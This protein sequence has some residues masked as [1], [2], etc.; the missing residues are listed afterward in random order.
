VQDI[1]R[2]GGLVWLSLGQWLAPVAYLFLAWLTEGR[3]GAAATIS[4]VDA[5]GVL[6][7]FRGWLW[8]PWVLQCYGLKWSR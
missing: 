5:A 8:N 2:T 1:A 7:D 6:S 4:A 3:G